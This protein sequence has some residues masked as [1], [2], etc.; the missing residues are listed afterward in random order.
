[1]EFQKPK[2]VYDK[3]EILDETDVVQDDLINNNPLPS[4]KKSVFKAKISIIL[5]VLF[6][7]IKLFNLLKSFDSIVQPGVSSF[8]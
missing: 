5:V 4:S 8:G 6:L 1:M 2:I 3:D 7:V